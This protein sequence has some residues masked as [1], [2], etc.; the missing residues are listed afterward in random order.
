MEAKGVFL[1]TCAAAFVVAPGK[2]TE[3]PATWYTTA[4]DSNW[5]TVSME[6]NCNTG[7]GTYPGSV[8]GISNTERA[9]FSSA[10]TNSGDEPCVL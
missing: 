1:A 8:F 4:T 7:A 2:A 6:N 3:A 9:T 5:V 10:T